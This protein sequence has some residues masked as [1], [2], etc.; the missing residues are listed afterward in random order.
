MSGL[1]G[2][3]PRKLHYGRIERITLTLTYEGL[4]CLLRDEVPPDFTMGDFDFDGP[5]EI[6]LTRETIDS[7][8]SERGDGQ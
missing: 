1:I 3:L 6:V 8:P 2:K 4:R 5:I 7:P